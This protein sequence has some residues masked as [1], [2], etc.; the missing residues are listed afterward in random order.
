M[1]QLKPGHAGLQK[2]ATLALRS[3]EACYQLV[4]LAPVVLILSTGAVTV[5]FIKTFFS[6]KKGVLTV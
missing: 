3:T 6:A 4:R 2:D 5:D 1:F